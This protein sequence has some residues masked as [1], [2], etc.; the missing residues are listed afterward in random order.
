MAVPANIAGW[1]LREGV[2]AGVFGVA[3]LGSAQGVAAATVYGVMVFVASLPGA[4]VLVMARRRRGSVAVDPAPR[5]ALAH[6]AG[7]S[8]RPVTVGGPEGAGHG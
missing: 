7:R 6:G 4:V 8:R 2:A 5:G 1:G 3:G